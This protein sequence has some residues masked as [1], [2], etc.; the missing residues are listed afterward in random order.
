MKYSVKYILIE[1]FLF[2]P[3]FC[4]FQ[5]FPS[6]FLRY[7]VIFLAGSSP[8]DTTNNQQFTVTHNT[9][10]LFFYIFSFCPI[11]CNK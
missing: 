6:H 5:P 2:L 8:P 11:T 4:P 1:M 10:I 7:S 9:Q 3:V